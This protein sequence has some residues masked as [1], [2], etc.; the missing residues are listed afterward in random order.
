MDIWLIPPLILLCLLVEAFYAGSEI[1]VVSADRLRLR[2][3]AAKGSRGAQLAMEMLKKP[4]HLLTTTLV[5]INVAI[6]TNSSLSTLFAIEVL[7]KEQ[8]WIAIVIAAPLIWV[9]GE[10]VPKSIFQQKADYLAPRIIYVLKASSILFYPLIIIFSILFRAIT[11]LFGGGEKNNI[12]SLREEIDMVLQM[13]NQETDILPVERSM[14]R[15]L[16]NFGETTARDI[17]VPLIDIRAVDRNATCGETLEFSAQSSHLLL[18]V[19]AGRVDNMI[20]Y[21]NTVDLLNV[22]AEQSI[23]GFVRPIAYAPGAKSIE[24]ILNACQA[25]GERMTIIVDEY[26]SCEGLVTLE[27]ILERVVGEM[28]DEYDPDKKNIVY[29]Q[30]VDN[31]SWRVNARISLIALKDELGI[32]LPDG[33]YETLAGFLLDHFREIPKEGEKMHHDGWAFTVTKAG[34]HA[35]REVVI[36]NG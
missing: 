10:I 27:D 32:Q 18:P 28:R 2:H 22:P 33:P 21:I 4:E 9:F 36:S 29:W 14:I 8:A 5:G 13:P 3:Q 12:F 20:G 34:R 25:T 17:M 16:F 31:D 11:F 1:A 7:G 26:G 15:R 6:V 24:D 35:I 23:R 30:R 19:Y